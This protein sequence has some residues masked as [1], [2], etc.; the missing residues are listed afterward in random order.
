MIR[1]LRLKVVAVCMLLVT[2]ILGGIVTALYF[3]ARSNIQD[4][5]E[6]LLHRLI[7]SDPRMGPGSSTIVVGRSEVQLPFFTVEL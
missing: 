6:R 4:S 1:R 3:S 7:V 2:A 5:S